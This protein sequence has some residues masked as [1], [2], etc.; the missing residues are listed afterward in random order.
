MGKKKSRKSTKLSQ[1][2]MLLL[3]ITNF[4]TNDKH[5]K[6]KLFIILSF[7]ISACSGLK[8]LEQEKPVLSIEKLRCMGDCPV[9]T[10]DVYKNGFILYDGKMFVSL[11]GKYSGKINKTELEE[12]QNKFLENGFFDFE[13]SYKAPVMDL[14]TTF[15]FFSYKGKEKKIRDYSNPPEGLKELEDLLS[16]LIDTVKWKALKN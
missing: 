1:I 5:M 4:E 3:R 2:Y 6:I 16:G 9:F 14:Q 7:L 11:S 12:L 10:L 13:N 8:N 15:I